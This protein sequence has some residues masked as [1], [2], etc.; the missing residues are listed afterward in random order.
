M[1][2]ADNKHNEIFY[3]CDGCNF[4]GITEGILNK[5]VE[6][7]HEEVITIYYNTAGTL[8]KLPQLYW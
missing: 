6:T 8:V 7:I 2:H 3:L 5:H 4:K 1:Q